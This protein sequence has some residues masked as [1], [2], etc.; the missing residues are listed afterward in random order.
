MLSGLT[1][2]AKIYIYVLQQRQTV[3]ANTHNVCRHCT[4][5]LS[6]ATFSK[7]LQKYNDWPWRK[8]L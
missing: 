3:I 2:F 7:T 1:Q 4:K 8:C 6:E 5:Y